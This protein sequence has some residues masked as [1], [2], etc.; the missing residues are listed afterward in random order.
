MNQTQ[1]YNK[2]LDTNNYY[3]QSWTGK[4]VHPWVIINFEIFYATVNGVKK[5]DSFW[6]HVWILRVLRSRLQEGLHLI[7]KQLVLHDVIWGLSPTIYICGSR[8]G[9]FVWLIHFM[10]LGIIVFLLWVFNLSFLNVK[11][12]IFT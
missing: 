8:S 12:P 5:H 1:A 10:F 3:K 9:M 7:W 11:N 6:I 2:C 4:V